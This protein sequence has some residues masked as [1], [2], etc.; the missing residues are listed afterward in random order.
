M[1]K[2]TDIQVS[3]SEDAKIDDL[4]LGNEALNIPNLHAK[5]LSILTSTKLSQRKCESD[6]W[7]MRKKKYRYYRGEMTKPELLEEEWEQWQGTKPLK[8]EMDEFLSTDSDLILLQDKVEY[9]KTVVYQLEQI[10]RSLNSR[11]W[12]IK[13]A[14]DMRKLE[15]GG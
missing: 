6:Y 3:W 15:A 14:V 2:L 4:K 9:Y 1:A 10:M 12:E 11:V 8:S 13:L 7:R 5:Y